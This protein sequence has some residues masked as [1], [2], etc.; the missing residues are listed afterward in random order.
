M[1]I[2]MPFG[3][4]RGEPLSR[5][6][7]MSYLRWCLRKC[8]NLEEY[9]RDAIAEEVRRRGPREDRHPGDAG[10]GAAGGTTGQAGAVVDLQPIIARWY[11]ELCLR[12]HPD[13]GG[14]TE[15]MHAVNDAHDRLRQLVGAGR[16]QR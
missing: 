11:R 4:Y 14:S 6:P 9:L 15:A 16:G 5:V 8:D 10:Y 2:H 12:W 7:L 1:V 13:R 3:R